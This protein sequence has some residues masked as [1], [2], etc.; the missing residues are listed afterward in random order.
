M[1]NRILN[2]NRIEVIQVSA[3]RKH[4]K[5]FEEAFEAT[6]NSMTEM[7]LKNVHY[8]GECSNSHHRNNGSEENSDNEADDGKENCDNKVNEGLEESDDM[9]I[10]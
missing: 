2:S 5:S 1:V 7:Q 6:N 4:Y 8:T 9:D 10:S 3:I